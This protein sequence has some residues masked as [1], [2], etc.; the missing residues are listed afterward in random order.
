VEEISSTSQGNNS[1]R[2][3][4]PSPA[5]ESS[6][7]QEQAPQQSNDPIEELLSSILGIG[8]QIGQRPREPSANGSS[9]A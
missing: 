9:P 5:T 4:P 6:A 1:Q 2:S 7:R 3:R 8:S